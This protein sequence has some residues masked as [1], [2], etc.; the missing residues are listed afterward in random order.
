MEK[1]F[2]LWWGD[3][4]LLANFSR[5]GFGEELTGRQFHKDVKFIDESF[6]D[7]VV[8]TVDAKDCG[9]ILIGTTP[10]FVTPYGE[11]VPPR[12][13]QIIWKSTEAAK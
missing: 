10:A 2:F 3:S 11:R 4:C 12:A 7:W 8:K 5:D 1:R 6:V 9:I 13:Y